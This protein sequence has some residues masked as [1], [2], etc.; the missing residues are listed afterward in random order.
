MGYPSTSST[1][2]KTNTDYYYEHEA[3][4]Y[5]VLPG[6]LHTACY[7]YPVRP[8][9]ST[10][11]VIGSLEAWRRWKWEMRITSPY[12]STVL[13]YCRTRLLVSN[14][15]CWSFFDRWVVGKM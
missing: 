8:T 12:C 4:L 6:V 5:S 11:I 10:G 7:E 2:V 15:F 13:T 14:S 1:R 3:L 9:E